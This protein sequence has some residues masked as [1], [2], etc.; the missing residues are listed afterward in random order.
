L[1]YFGYYGLTSYRWHADIKPDNI[2][3]VDGKFKLADPGFAK[4]VKM[5]EKD[6]IDLKQ[7]V[8]GGT[9][10]Y[11]KPKYLSG[12]LL[13]ACSDK[14]CTGAPERLLA[15]KE[16][17]SVLQ[18]I[19]TWSL[20]C[21]FSVAATWVVLGYQGTRQ[22]SLMRQTAVEKIIKEGQSGRRPSFA[23]P[24]LNPGDY[25]HDGQN[26]LTDI[27]DWHKVL[28]NALRKNDHITSRVL[29]LVDDGMLLGNAEKRWKA[30]RVCEELKQILADAQARPIEHVPQQ[31]VNALIAVDEAAP[32]KAGTK[33][34]EAQPERKQHLTIAD[35]R[36]ARKSKR[37]DLPLMKTSHRSEGRKSAA[38]PPALET[39]PLTPI[40]ESPVEMDLPVSKDNIIPPPQSQT[41]SQGGDAEP[42]QRNVHKHSPPIS[43]TMASLKRPT[44][45]NQRR[46]TPQNVFQAREAIGEREKHNFLKRTRKDDRLTAYYGNRDIVSS[47]PQS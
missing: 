47:L 40:S 34:M 29:N 30:E 28:R 4:F 44:L 43:P 13:A 41:P 31:I 15:G 22:F 7:F 45:V 16:A 20:G 8:L 14:L 17:V 32:S 1:S 26:V 5:T 3:S 21:V 46:T 33:I 12:T 39:E 6:D 23:M 35:A 11:G 36:Q 25:F 19:D 42:L 37:L 38:P 2:L 18:T 24:K 27:K 9:E 10:T